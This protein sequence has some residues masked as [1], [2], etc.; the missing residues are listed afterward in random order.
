MIQSGFEQNGSP[1]A[2][3][4]LPVAARSQLGEFSSGGM[5]RNTIRKALYSAMVEAGA[6]QECLAL[7][8]EHGANAILPI[9]PLSF[10]PLSWIF[11]T[12][13]EYLRAVQEQAG[14]PSLLRE[15][16]DLRQQHGPLSVLDTLHAGE[17]EAPEFSELPGIALFSIP[18]N[19]ESSLIEA[20]VNEFARLVRSKDNLSEGF[21]R[22]GLLLLLG[23]AGIPARNLIRHHQYYKIASFAGLSG[24][25]HFVAV[26][27][28]ADLGLGLLPVQMG[29]LSGV[30]K[31]ILGKLAASGRLGL[32]DGRA[33]SDR[34]IGGHIARLL[35][36]TGLHVKSGA[37]TTLTRAW[38]RVSN[39]KALFNLGGLLTAGLASRLVLPP[40]YYD[41]GDILNVQND[42]WKPLEAFDGGQWRSPYV[43]S[44]RS[45]Q[46]HLSR[47]EMIR[48]LT[49]KSLPGRGGK[50][51]MRKLLPV[52]EAHLSNWSN[53]DLAKCF[54]HYDCWPSRRKIAS[55][56]VES[57]A[58]FAVNAD[59][60]SLQIFRLIQRQGCLH[61]GRPLRLV[62]SGC[63][64][65]FLTE[66]LLPDIR[67][68]NPEM[69]QK[70]EGQILAGAAVAMRLGE[71]LRLRVSDYHSEGRFDILHIRG[72]KTWR[73][74][75]TFPLH[76]ARMGLHGNMLVSKFIDVM[77]ER[78]IIVG[79]QLL[80]GHG[81]E[82]AKRASDK[83][84]VILDQSFR[85]FRKISGD[86]LANDP[87]IDGRFTHHSLRHGAA[88]RMLQGIVNRTFGSGDLWGAVSELALSMGQSL[89]THLCSYIGTA[90]LLL[91]RPS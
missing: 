31:I 27:P 77:Q 80:F 23:S 7:I 66:R 82:S 17:T 51:R 28:Q 73:A 25:L 57:G 40:N 47:S 19:Q 10:Y 18:T 24:A 42:A 41:I 9:G 69:S 79:D 81:D 65:E 12:A 32:F 71:A 13:G 38:T 21:L 37:C 78:S 46:N 43:P 56:L 67:E 11:S 50:G 91:K 88:L 14:V 8:F 2:F 85:T 75:R 68:G 45:L 44:E 6:G 54:V 83:L 52:F 70:M 74:S 3:A 22:S 76:L 86:C 29:G 87:R 30:T 49:R 4:G 61:A 15:L 72:T 34:E 63:A 53:E 26:M 48:L 89:N 35:R 36:N 20:A 60:R 84:A 5:P 58:D 59:I 1:L 90:G 16:A 33:L 39:F 55:V 62:P 64:S